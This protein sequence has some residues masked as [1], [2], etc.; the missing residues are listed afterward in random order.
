MELEVQKK[1]ITE[2][3]GGMTQKEAGRT[4]RPQGRSNTSGK[5]GRRKDWKEESQTA[6]QLSKSHGQ[7]NGE[8]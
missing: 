2:D 7:P 5:R 1:I 8:L 3:K 6:V 4:F